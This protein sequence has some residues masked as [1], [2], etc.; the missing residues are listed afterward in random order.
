MEKAKKTVCFEMYTF[1][2]GIFKEIFGARV[3]FKETQCMV[4]GYDQREFKIQKIKISEKIDQGI[5]EKNKRW[6]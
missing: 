2:S 3:D 1:L 4:Q 6:R 5:S